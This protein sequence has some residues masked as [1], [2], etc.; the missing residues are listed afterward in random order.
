M[1]ELEVSTGTIH[2]VELNGKKYTA[3]GPVGLGTFLSRSKLNGVTLLRLLIIGAEHHPEIV[4]LPT[5]ERLDSMGGG[6]GWW[7]K[8]PAQK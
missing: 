5:K 8:W 6:V 2:G 3:E 1:S 7:W 4:D